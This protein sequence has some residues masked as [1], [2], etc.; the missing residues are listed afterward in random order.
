MTDSGKSS[1]DKPD[2]GFRIF[3]TDEFRENL[4]RDF[5]GG[6]ERIKAK[7]CAYVY[8]QL[9]KNPYIGK[10]IKKLFNYKPETWRYRIGSRRFFYSIDDKKKIVFMIAYD[11][12]QNA[13]K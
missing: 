3:E 5:S 1:K 6:Q 4:N 11:T 7:L 13:Y 2:S 9:R 12:R 10:N 8:P